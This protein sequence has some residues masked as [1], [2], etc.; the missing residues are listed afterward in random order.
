MWV[1]GLRIQH[2]EQTPW[3]SEGGH[4]GSA[5]HLL[6]H[7]PRLPVPR[8]RDLLRGTHIDEDLSA[9]VYITGFDDKAGED[10]GSNE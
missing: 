2:K 6:R 5:P 10:A 4:L 1:A 3:V 7:L 9:I 8:C